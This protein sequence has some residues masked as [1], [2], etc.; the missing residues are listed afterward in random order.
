MP[1]LKICN[2]LGTPL[3]EADVVTL[4]PPWQLRSSIEMSRRRKGILESAGF[5]CWL[6]TWLFVEILGNGLAD[7]DNTVSREYVPVGL[8]SSHALNRR[9]RFHGD[10]LW[11]SAQPSKLYN[12]PT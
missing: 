1:G 8:A 12:T 4:W 5:F 6:T 10:K 11:M 9:S 2:W 7:S 3:L